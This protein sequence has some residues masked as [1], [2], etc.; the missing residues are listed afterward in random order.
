MKEKK[1][2][3]GLLLG[4]AVVFTLVAIVTLIPKASASKECLFG[5]KALCSFAPIS[6]IILIVLAGALCVLRKRKFTQSTLVGTGDE[7][8]A[9]L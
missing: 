1:K 7:S 2:G 3:Y 9:G 8:A 6:T 5:Y 4:L